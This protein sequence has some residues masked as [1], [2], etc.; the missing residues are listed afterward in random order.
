[1]GV[2]L[3]MCLNSRVAGCALLTTGEPI[4]LGSRIPNTEIA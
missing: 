4:G 2:K 1:L 3:L